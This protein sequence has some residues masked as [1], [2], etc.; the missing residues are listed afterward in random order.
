MT[1][2]NSIAL[3]IWWRK[4]VTPAFGRLVAG[5][6][7]SIGVF[8]L[9]SGM[10]ATVFFTFFFLFVGLHFFLLLSKG[11]PFPQSS[12]PLPISNIDSM[13]ALYLFFAGFLEA[14][15]VLGATFTG[16]CA[17]VGLALA[18]RATSEETLPPVVG[19]VLV[20][21]PGIFWAFLLV[22]ATIA[23]L[24]CLLVLACV[25]MM[26]WALLRL[27]LTLREKRDRLLAENPQDVSAEEKVGL[28][29]SLPSGSS[30]LPKKRL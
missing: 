8:L 10:A 26:F 3:K 9:V 18:I 28:E 11:T 1:S 20:G 5:F 24:L 2:Q 23:L 13:H 19:A 21:M 14:H 16:G 12:L 7:F 22:L 4:S 6:L 30:A 25:G 17:V 27:P 15:P 29:E